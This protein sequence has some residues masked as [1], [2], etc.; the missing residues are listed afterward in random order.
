[1]P[2]A[3]VDAIDFVTPQQNG[4]PA[5]VP[6]TLYDGTTVNLPS[7]SSGT[8]AAVAPAPASSSS[9]LTIMLLFA[10]VLGGAILLRKL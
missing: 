9:A 3:S 7:L 6:L 4:A 10:V 1:M 8:T 5:G 2:A